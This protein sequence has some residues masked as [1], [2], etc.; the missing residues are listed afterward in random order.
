[1][2]FVIQNHYFVSEHINCAI[3]SRMTFRLNH[4]AIVSFAIFEKKITLLFLLLLYPGIP[5]SFSSV[6]SIE[7]CCGF[8]PLIGPSKSLSSTD[9]LAGGTLCAFPFALLL[10]MLSIS[11]GMKSGGIR[12]GLPEPIVRVISIDSEL[13]GGGF[14][15]ITEG[16]RD[17]PLLLGGF[18]FLSLFCEEVVVIEGRVVGRLVLAFGLIDNVA[19]GLLIVPNL[20]LFGASVV[21]AGN[22]SASRG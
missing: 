22:N 15:L 5:F 4:S 19:D 7:C 21:V 9:C 2:Q 8:I 10:G 11:G 12:G 6:S 13:E 1:M 14:G 16:G 18:L 17:E 20:D 3:A